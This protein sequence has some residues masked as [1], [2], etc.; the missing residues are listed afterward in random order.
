[1]SFTQIGKA[2]PLTMVPWNEQSILALRGEVKTPFTKP[3]VIVIA[4]KHE[5]DTQVF[6][7][8]E[9]LGTSPEN[10]R[11]QPL[12][13]QKTWPDKPR[14]SAPWNREAS[15]YI[16]YVYEN[17]D[18]LPNHT[19][20]IH[21]RPHEELVWFN[22]VDCM[23]PNASYISISKIFIQNRGTLGIW[24][25]EA[26][27]PYVEQC[28]RDVAKMSGKPFAPKVEPMMS[29]PCCAHFIA[30]REQLRSR[31]FSYWEAMHKMVSQ[32]REGICHEGP[33]DVDELVHPRAA[34]IGP[35][36]EATDGGRH[37]VAGAFEHLA[38]VIFGLED[39]KGVLP[40]QN[41]YCAQFYPSS[42]CPGSLCEA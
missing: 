11:Y 34:E 17:Y 20:F 18:N 24:G 13:Y 33:L 2:D 6:K 5:F 42:V 29:G 38:H 39:H 10:K 7:W 26:Y 37:T 25:H 21:A 8:L 14:Y 41:E 30:S 32:N 16:Q 22:H 31:P 40:G 36:L 28:W 1:M 15:P 27:G 35:E 12:V 3:I 9:W 19:L 23:R 4:S